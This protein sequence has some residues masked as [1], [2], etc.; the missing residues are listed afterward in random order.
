MS[1]MKKSFSPLKTKSLF[2]IALLIVVT[3]FWLVNFFK[4]SKDVTF[5]PNNSFINHYIRDIENSRK[6]IYI[7]IYFFKTDDQKGLANDLKL[8]LLRARERGVQV[9]MV[10]D[11]AGN[12][13]TTEANSFTGQDL[14]KH[15]IKVRYDSPFVKLHSKL[16]VIDEKI[17][18]IGSHNYTNSALGSNNETSVRI[19]SQA[20]AKDAI[21]YITSLKTYD[22]IK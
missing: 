19:V 4:N 2:L 7:S 6:S 3:V 1:S 15:G 14:E 17:V 16:T 10:M 21:S 18:Y 8:A 11:Q 22:L 5:L 12:D 13:I 20:L 9:Y